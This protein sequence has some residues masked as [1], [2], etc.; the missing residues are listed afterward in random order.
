MH[1][2][3][4]IL[5]ISIAALSFAAPAV[6]EQHEP[7][8]AEEAETLTADTVMATVNGVEI[9]LGHMIAARSSLPPEYNNVPANELYNGI[10][11]Q[12]VQ[13]EALAQTVETMP[14]LVVLTF[15]NQERSARAGLA[16]ERDVEGA[17]TEEDV[18]AAYDA[19]FAD[20]DSEE[21]FNASHILVSTEEE[22]LAIKAE[23]DAGANFAAL[24]REKSTGPSGPNGG[25]LGWFGPGA[26][27]PTFE[28][29]TIALGIG[30]IS[31]PVQTQFGWHVI[32]LNDARKTEP[33]ALEQVYGNFEEQ[34]RQKAAQDVINRTAEAATVLIPEHEAFDPQILNR[35]DLL[36][37]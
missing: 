13:L 9:T 35:T 25:S 33:P 4:G 16:L 7:P 27:V 6:A 5:A 11:Q 29:A 19:A 28:A 17:V 22:A 30:E 18:R 20:F 15:E 31:E 14:P 23:L 21:E 37:E 12:L 1:I 32:R 34:L 2:H 36:E 8:Q 3:T 24:A 26:M 10:L